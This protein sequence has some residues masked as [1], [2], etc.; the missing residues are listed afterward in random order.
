MAQ[1]SKFG[2]KAY[3]KNSNGTVDRGLMQINTWLVNAYE[4]STGKKVNAYNP[5][6]NI[7]MGVWLLDYFKN[8][9]AEEV[10]SKY[11]EVFALTAYNKGEKVALKK[12]GSEDGY[13][14]SVLFY[15]EQLKKYKTVKEW[16]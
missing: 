16:N 1:E 11:F 3:N 15:K 7:D 13:A 5:Y 2:E 6:D 4:K 14:N 10:P 12:I 8:K 9:F